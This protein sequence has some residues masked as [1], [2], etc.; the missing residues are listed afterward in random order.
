MC[1]SVLAF[2]YTQCTNKYKPCMLSHFFLVLYV[3]KADHSSLDNYIGTH[4][5]EKQSNFPFPRYHYLY[6]LA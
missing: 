2:L 4:P 6:F 1:V 5:W 3:F